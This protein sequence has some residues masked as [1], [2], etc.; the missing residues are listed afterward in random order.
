MRNAPDY[1][2]EE[3]KIINDYRHDFIYVRGYFDFAKELVSNLP[4]KKELTYLT[5][6][7]I[8]LD[9]E[10]KHGVRVECRK[11]NVILILKALYRVQID[12]ISKNITLNLNETGMEVLH[13][14]IPK[15]KEW[16][17]QKESG[18]GT[19]SYAVKEIE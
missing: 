19:I 18:F 13:L 17:S 8:L 4:C 11:N 5:V 12:K 9:L 15:K 2:L 6:A 7:N 1:K 14:S 16:Y 10:Y 3:Q